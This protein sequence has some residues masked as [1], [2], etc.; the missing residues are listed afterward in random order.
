MRL[1]HQRSLLQV[2]DRHGFLEVDR[3]A[4]ALEERVDVDRA[5]G[6]PEL[7]HVAGPEHLQEQR[8]FD[9]RVA[10]LDLVATAPVGDLLNVVDR[11]EVRDGFQ[12]VLSRLDGPLRIGGQERQHRAEIVMV[13]EAERVPQG[14]RVWQRRPIGAFVVGN[15][16]AGGRAEVL[17][18]SP[19][20]LLVDDVEKRA[21]GGRIA[22]PAQTPTQT[23]LCQ[24]PA[25]KRNT[26]SGS[27]SAAVEVAAIFL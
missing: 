6:P 7:K 17:R 15:E 12:I 23:L 1:D 16:K 3:H 10:V 19:G 11:V 9:V 20:V 26:S 25:P 4:G 22:P 18:E 2:R 5:G 13:P 14:R 21:A 8:L 27:I 24:K